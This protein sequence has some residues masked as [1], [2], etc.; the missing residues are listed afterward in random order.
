VS[1]TPDPKDKS[2][3]ISASEK[4]CTDFIAAALEEE[5]FEWKTARLM[6]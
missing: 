4:P 3:E 1:L 2:E 6:P 5:L